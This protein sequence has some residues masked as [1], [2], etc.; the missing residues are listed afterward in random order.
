MD[1]EN[2]RHPQ[3][4]KKSRMIGASLLNDGTRL[5]DGYMYS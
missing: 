2:Q 3:K 5:Y 1:F 4:K